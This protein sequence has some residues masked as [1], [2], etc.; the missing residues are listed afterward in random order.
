VID[1]PYP[2]TEYLVID[3]ASSDESCSVA[4]EFFPKLTLISERDEGQADA[5]NKGVSRVTGEVIGWLN[6]DDYYKPSALEKVAAE[7]ARRP[8]VGLV[9]GNAEFVNEYGQVLGIATHVEPFNLNRLITV[10][11][12]IVQPAA[13]FRRSAFQAVGMLRPELNWSID[14]DLW[15][16]LAKHF[17]V[18]YIDH[19]LACVRCYLGTKT[20]SGGRARL[21][22]VEQMIKGHGGRGLPIYFRLEAAALSAREAVLWAEQKKYLQAL[23]SAAAA[24]SELFGSQRSLAALLSPRTWRVIRAAHKRNLLV[25]RRRRINAIE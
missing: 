8:D 20:S 9:Y 3:G 12:Y 25:E 22:E 2:K 5:I 15:I 21:A 19:T 17:G 11:D 16:R 7:F 23:T 6:A 14:Y 13:F 4:A 24:I 18:S 10:G 1:Q